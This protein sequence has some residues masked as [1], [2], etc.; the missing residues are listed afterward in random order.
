MSKLEGAFLL[1]RCSR[2]DI[3]GKEILK[4]Q[5]KFFVC[6][7]AMRYGVL[8]YTSDSVAAMRGSRR[9]MS[10]IF[11]CQMSLDENLRFMYG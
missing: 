3:Q 4:T 1:H 7:P 6:D 5:E 9:C 8:G 2:Y 11:S 10:Q